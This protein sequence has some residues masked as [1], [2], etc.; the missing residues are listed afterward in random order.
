MAFASV[1]GWKWRRQ[2]GDGSGDGRVTGRGAVKRYTL[3]ELDTGLEFEETLP[4]LLLG[5]FPYSLAR[6]PGSCLGTVAGGS[7]EQVQGAEL[8]PALALQG[9]AH[10]MGNHR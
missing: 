1:R 7:G 10:T 3:S 8:S 4:P 2:G 5:H 9:V 6:I